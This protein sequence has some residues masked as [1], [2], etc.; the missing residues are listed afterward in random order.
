MKGGA[1]GFNITF[2]LR[3]DSYTTSSMHAHTIIGL[4]E[5]DRTQEFCVGLIKK[6]GVLCE[7]ADAPTTARPQRRIT[8]PVLRGR[9]A[10]HFMHQHPATGG[11]SQLGA[12]CQR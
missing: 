6:N 12:G 3:G 8:S 2:N 10:H 1:G 9:S 4:Q 7:F 11:F 5:Q